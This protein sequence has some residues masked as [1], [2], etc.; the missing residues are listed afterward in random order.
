MRR[1]QV[2]FQIYKPMASMPAPS[3]I[4]EEVQSGLSY[5]LDGA[6]RKDAN[7]QLCYTLSGEGAF[8]HCSETYR[9]LPGTM[10]IT[11]NN[12]PKNSYYFPQACRQPWIF[13]WFS[14]W[15][16]ASGRMI[17]D[18][19]EGYG[20]VFSV[21]RELA[22][23]RKIVSYQKYSN[24]VRVLSP[25]AGAK[26]VVDSLNDI[27]EYLDNRHAASPQGEMIK[28]IQEY[29]M[30][31]IERDISVCKMSSE[32]GISRE[33]LS[34]TFKAHLGIPLHDYVTMEKMKLACQLL[35]ET[36]MPCKEI[37]GKVGYGNTIGFNRAF[38]SLLNMTP[39]ELRLSGFMPDF[40]I[41]SR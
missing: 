1:W 17:D 31:N 37:S 26:L 34:R 8:R 15:G 4:V 23:I 25:L 30:K 19:V 21:P 36:R 35:L 6:R 27:V 24:S 2:R 10:F 13:I 32:L 3:E 7:C 38:K 16:E 33:H 5:R 9:L 20:H 22:A 41:D 11:R 18:I 40:N 29:V 28:N 14:F 39:S 12:D